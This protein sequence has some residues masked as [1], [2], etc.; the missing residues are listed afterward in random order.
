MTKLNTSSKILALL[1]IFG[2]MTWLGGSIVRSAIAYDIFVPFSANFELK[3]YYTNEVLVHNVY[4]FA[5]T[6][7]Y[8][9]VGYGISFLSVILLAFINKD[10]LKKEGWFFMIV[11][12][13]IIFAPIEIYQMILDY[14]L[15]MG[16]RDKIITQFNSPIV[17]D[18]FMQ[19]LTY[20]PI[21]TY[22]VLSF[23]SHLA[24]ITF[25]IIKPL[26]VKE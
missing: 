23:L 7:I 15:N 19:R 3:N 25:M 16:F 17:N 18:N 4:L 6:S 22:S 21:R 26:R 14:N 11:A 10:K 24:A 8:P 13:Y 9:S 12:L 1:A 2:I 5:N 20:V